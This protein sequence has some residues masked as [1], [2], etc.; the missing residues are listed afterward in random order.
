[1]GIPEYRLI[2]S[3]PCERWSLGNQEGF[4]R[5]RRAGSWQKESFRVLPTVV[6]MVGTCLQI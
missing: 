1:M 2:E 3:D 6:K 5:E 4:S